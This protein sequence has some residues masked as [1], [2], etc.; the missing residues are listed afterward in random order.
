MGMCSTLHSEGLRGMDYGNTWGE[1]VDFLTVR[2]SG[3]MMHVCVEFLT[4]I[5]GSVRWIFDLLSE[6][7]P[8]QPKPKLGGKENL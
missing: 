4:V 2:D 6:R 3:F 5:R 7:V 1:C 8:L